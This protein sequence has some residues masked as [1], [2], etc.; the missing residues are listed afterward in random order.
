MAA[1]VLWASA[2]VDFDDA[3]QATSVTVQLQA[4]EGLTLDL[5]NKT[6]TM[7]LGG[8]TTTVQTDSEGAAVFSNVVP[9][10]YDVSV[11]WTITA[12]EYMAAG[13]GEAVATT[14]SASLN[15]QLIAGAEVL[16]MQL[17]ASAQ[18]D[19][20]IGKVYYAGS[21]D[22]NN[23]N[24][25]AGKYIELYN[26]SDDTVDVSGLYIGLTESES[27]QA[28]TRSDLDQTYGSGAVV[29]LKQ[30]YRIPTD[31]SYMV[32][33]GGTVVICNSAIDH[34]DGNDQESDLTEADF[35]VKDTQGN[36]QNNPA[37]PAMQMIYQIY[38][39]TSVMNL[40]QSGPTGVVIFRT[41][42][43][44]TAWTKVYKYGATSGLQYVVCPTSCILDGMEALRRK[45][46]GIDVTTKR[47]PDC[48]DAGYTSINAVSGWNA[49]VVYRRTRC[50]QSGHKVLV[51]TN[52]SSNDCQTSTTI[53]PRQYDDC[54][55]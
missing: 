31:D 23:R 33:P 5:G 37:V 53:K 41:D 17:L 1:T 51:D 52:N 15:S 30:I 54:Q 24:Y 18:R 40:V 9:D 12:D 2:C 25:M 6:V 7:Q 36:Y 11:S 43:D 14:V 42:Q 26:Q 22:N 38:A 4:P 10:V 49:E 44:V 27:T 35:E 13:G 8:Q 28:W 3:T 19:I 16:Y 39:G 20:V 29:L 47:L 48:V 46:S 32:A 45:T 21:K 50:L 34:T 55:E